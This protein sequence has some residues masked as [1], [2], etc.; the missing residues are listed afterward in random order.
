MAIWRKV[1][2]TFICFMMFLILY[3]ILRNGWI[4][5]ISIAP[6]PEYGLLLFLLPGMVT[7]LISRDSAIFSSLSEGWFPFLSVFYCVWPFTHAFVH[8]FR[9]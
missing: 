3:I 5:V 4:V 9:N 7:S 8:W 2:A 1:L 6:G